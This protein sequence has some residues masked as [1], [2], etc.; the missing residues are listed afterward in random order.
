[1]L[2]EGKKSLTY[3]L[4]GVAGS[5]LMLRNNIGTEVL[6]G[7]SSENLPSNRFAGFMDKPLSA[8]VSF[9]TIYVLN[10][11]HSD[12]TPGTW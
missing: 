1:M 6:I 7:F 10:Q 5:N 11:C 4:N 2:S 8:K 12:F 3:A 9:A